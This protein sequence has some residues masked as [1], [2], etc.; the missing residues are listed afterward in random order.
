MTSPYP[1]PCLIR[2]LRVRKC[3]STASARIGLTTAGCRMPAA[4]P[5]PLAMLEPRLPLLGEGREALGRVAPGEQALL[6]L[7]LQR[8]VLVEA[9]LE[10]ADHRALDQAD[11]LAGARGLRLLHLVVLR[12]VALRSSDGQDVTGRDAPKIGGPEGYQRLGL[13]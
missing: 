11:R 5:A 1:H 4:R 3:R 2:H 12:L 8:Q 6:Q 13:P 9:H 10:A 7:A